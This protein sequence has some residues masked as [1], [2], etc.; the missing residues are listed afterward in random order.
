M[1]ARTAARSRRVGTTC[2]CPPFLTTRWVPKKECCLFWWEEGG[3]EGSQGPSLL[4]ALD[5]R[6]AEVA[7]AVSTSMSWRPLPLALALRAL[8]GRGLLR[9]VALLLGCRVA[10]PAMA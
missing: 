5:G 7:V 6:G 3:P 4:C 8:E 2:V 10:A 9:L 1:A